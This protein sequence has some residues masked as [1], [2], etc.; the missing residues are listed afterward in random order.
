MKLVHKHLLTATLLA[1]LGATAVAQTQTP[2]P[3][4]V[5]PRG[6][7]A[8][9]GGLPMEHMDPARMHE[10]RQVRMER[11]LAALKLKLAIAPAQEGAWTAWTTAMKPPVQ[12]QA[13]PSR[14]DFERMTTPER[15][16]RMR[17][18][19]TTRQ[20]EM[21][22]RMD[23]TKTFYAALSADQKKVFDGESMQMMRGGRD[24]HRGGHGMH[25]R[26]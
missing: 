14:V 21:D 17:A 11:R 6:E 2:P 10:M 16:D 4:Q 9:R 1:A 23:A 25:H 5:G 12:P 19:R 3:P 13:R 18:L 15:I 26:G 8:Q 20:A 24:G 7:M 22:R